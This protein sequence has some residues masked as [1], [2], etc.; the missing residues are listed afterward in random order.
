[1]KGSPKPP[2]WGAQHECCP[3]GN[4][5]I[6]P[7]VET[8]IAG[9]AERQHGNVTL[10]QLQFLGLGRSGVSRRAKSGRLFRIHRGVYAVGRP[11]LTQRGHWMAAVLA[12]GPQAVLS[13]R[14]AAALHGIRADNRAKTD[15]TL[16]S[17]S[18]RSRPT[19]DVHTSLT[20]EA[21][22]I[23]TVDR[24]PCTTVARTLVDLGDIVSR[25][26]VERAVDR[27][28]VL[29]V[30]DGR[31]VHEALERAG[32]RRGAG[33]L[34]AV[35]ESY[36]GPT[37]TD[38]ELEERFLALCRQAS[39]PSPA[40]N[41]WITLTDG[42]AYKAD[43]L[44]RTRRLI[45]ETDGRDVHTTRKAFEHDRLRDQ[46][47]TLAGFTVVRFTWRQVAN[48]PQRVAEALRSLLARLARP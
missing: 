10:P 17:P 22:D 39:L 43:F 12:C 30:F 45:A 28:E 41:A 4:K 6:E 46:R 9:F 44:W 19:I 8:L 34:R 25:R 26:E 35:L 31:A 3:T 7:H 16:P 24:I 14:S 29:R 48:E 13:H 32:P 11:D 5:R 36:K 18:A 2:G 38:K 23:T 37:L 27:A 47:L 42:I 15:V 20:L 1:M 40:V 21:A 33:T